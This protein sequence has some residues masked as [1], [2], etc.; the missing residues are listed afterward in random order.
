MKTNYG[1]KIAPPTIE[2]ARAFGSNVEPVPLKGGQN[3]S[4]LAGNIVLKPAGGKSGTEWRAQVFSSLPESREVRFHRPIKSINGDW[5]HEGYVAWEFLKGEHVK[6]QYDK[7]LK[8]SHA[9]HKLLRGF[10]QPEGLKTPKGPWSTGNW[11]ALSQLEF[12]YDQEFM[13]LYNQI[14]PHLKPLPEDRQLVHGDMFQNFLLDEILP[15]ALIDFSGVWAPNGFAE[16]IMLADAINWGNATDEELEVFKQVPNIEQMA[17]RGAL[18][19]IAEL[20]EHIKFFGKEKA[21]AVKEA[22][23]LQKVFDYLNKNF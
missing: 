1:V 3:T 2:I 20:A 19:R 22:R 21:E 9:F 11:V 4:Y 6:G 10:P 17:W 23:N 5:A 8:A 12:D 14:K 13:D 15:P 18:T 7:K 16:G